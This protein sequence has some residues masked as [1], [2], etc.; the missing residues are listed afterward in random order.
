M[1]CALDFYERGS[2]APVA[3]TAT[4][5]VALVSIFGFFTLPGG[6][7]AGADMRIEPNKKTVILDEIFE[8]EVVV[9]SSTPVNVFAGEL[10]YDPRVF[11]VTA[12]DYNISVA[13]LWT[14]LPWYSN[15]EGVLT[16]GGGTTQKGGFLG[17]D[18]LFKVTF[19]T[20]QE[21]EG[22]V[23]V[24]EPRILRH[25]GF[26]A[27]AQLAEPVDAV[28]F[29]TNEQ[30][31]QA[32]LAPKT[33][34]SGRYVVTKTT[35]STDLNRDGRQTISDVSILLLNITG[36]DVRYDFNLD[37]EVDIKDLNILLSAD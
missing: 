12:I 37:G 4:A 23:S 35:P 29:V 25:D 33:D 20:L 34:I 14:E 16:F 27:D 18:T 28:F 24:H 30:S 15:G 17:V 19:Q 2:V 32:N 5:F 9:E 31:N 3:L 10:H 7:T 36:D 1:R 26:G 6:Q 21:G 11:A 8:V 22:I 13:D